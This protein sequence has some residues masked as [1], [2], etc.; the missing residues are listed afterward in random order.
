LSK[1]YD[2]YRPEGYGTWLQDIINP[3]SGLYASKLQMVF[4]IIDGEE[5]IR[6]QDENINDLVEINIKY[7]EE[8][9]INNPE[10]TFFIS[11]IDFW[12]RRIKSIKS[13]SQERGFEFLWE[14]RLFE[15]SKKYKNACVFD[16]KGIIENVGRGQFYSRKLW[17]LGGIKYTMMAEKL[18]EQEIN[19]YVTSIKEVRKKC[20]ILDLDNTLWGGVVGEVGLEG[21]EL[22]DYKEGARYKDFQKKLKEIKDLGI[23]LAVVSKNNFNDAI[24]VIKGHN[25]MVLKEEDFVAL[26]INWDLK[27]KNISLLSEEL[28]IGFDSI[29]FI[30][31][32]PVERESVKAELPE[33]V[34][35]DFPEDTS[36]LSDFAVELYYNYFYT[37]ST[38]DEDTAKTE[39]YRQNAMRR[40]AQ[41]SSTSYEDFLKSL[42]TKIEIRRMSEENIQ[43]AAQLTQKT[44]QFNLTT[45]RYSEQELLDLINKK[46]FSG[47]VVYVSDKFGDNGM[48]SVVI[49]RHKS[50]S[51]V[52]MDTFLLSC[53]VMGRFIEDQI[54][55]YVEELYK[56]LGYKKF[57]TYYKPTEKNAPVNELFERLGY[58][59]IDMDCTGSK[60]YI[61]DL[62]ETA[63]KCRKKF[64]ELIAI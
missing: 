52:E 56:E 5:L 41:K 62:E 61:L 12:A 27:S 30:D 35:P 23:I 13:D 59:L 6:G 25:H 58:E 63:L 46:D 8:A 44:N 47:F 1:Q 29:V 4:I 14:D 36:R 40:E 53:R 39:I 32:N 17:Y 19:R 20:L 51:E 43:R 24:K 28:N 33:V 45:R 34:V 54:I 57:I 26:K 49:T 42:E 21:I 2:V 3:N 22:S 60:K 10:I 48:V 18:L 55:S 15:L 31:D 37:L 50:N 64:G 7:V 16:L 9:I 11:N 38:T